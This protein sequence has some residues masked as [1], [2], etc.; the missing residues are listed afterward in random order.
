MR[1]DI[2]IF[3]FSLGVLFFSWPIMTIFR[4]NMVAALFVI[5]FVFILLV[6]LTSTFSGREDGS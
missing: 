4:D 3:L 5:W 2:I 1:R 6:F